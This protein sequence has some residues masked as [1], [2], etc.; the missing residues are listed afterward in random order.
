MTV[1]TPNQQ[2]YSSQQHIGTQ[3][4]ST[5]ASS[6]HAER[7]QV[8]PRHSD[9]TSSF[10]SHAERTQT[11]PRRSDTTTLGSHSMASFLED[12]L[13]NAR[14]GLGLQ[15]HSAHQRDAGSTTPTGTS[16]A[17]S[18]LIAIA[19]QRSEV[20]HFFP[21]FRT[22]V[23]PFILKDGDALELSIFTFL[24]DFEFAQA[25]DDATLREFTQAHRNRISVYLAC[26]ALGAQM[27][28]MSAAERARYADDF[29]KRLYIHVP[30]LSGCAYRYQ[31]IDP[32]RHFNFRRWYC[33]HASRVF[34]HYLWSACASRTRA[35]RMLLGHFLVSRSGSH[36]R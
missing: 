25:K 18:G 31:Y 11:T 3:N 27:S 7:A 29:G 13:Q 26:L 30:S 15:N 34:K 32:S 33:F 8:I 6:S 2:A 36:N 14:P 10:S 12:K 22:N 16:Y 35:P 20:F 9:T 4:S 5:I 24:S 17:S 1:T 19:P 21:I 23:I 28:E